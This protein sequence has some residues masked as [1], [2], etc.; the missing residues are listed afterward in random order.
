MVMSGGEGVPL[1]ILE[2]KVTELETQCHAIESGLEN[3][4]SS[5]L[6]EITAALEG[7]NNVK[8]EDLDKLKSS[9]KAPAAALKVLEGVCIVRAIKPEVGYHLGRKVA[10]YWEPSKKIILSDPDF[11]KTLREV[12]RDKITEESMMQLSNLV[13]AAGKTPNFV[14]FTMSGPHRGCVAARFC[15]RREKSFSGG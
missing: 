10:N 3:A 4:Q 14:R 9:K 2:A 1:E 8:R 15:R 5:D 7:L 6:S 13:D 12:E 11:A